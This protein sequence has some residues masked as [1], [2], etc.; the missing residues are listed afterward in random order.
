MLPWE[1]GG[2]EADRE[3]NGVEMPRGGRGGWEGHYFGGAKGQKINSSVL[4]LQ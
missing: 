3:D 2:E 4:T 1:R